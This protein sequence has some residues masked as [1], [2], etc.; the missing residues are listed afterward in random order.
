MMSKT[1]IQRTFE[2]VIESNRDKIYR[3]CCAYVPDRIVLSISVWYA[4]R[5]WNLRKKPIWCEV[6]AMLRELES[7]EPT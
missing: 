7:E 4:R 2:S 3:L 5:E 1:E 6:K